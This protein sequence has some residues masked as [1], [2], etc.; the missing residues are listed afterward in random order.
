MNIILLWI[1]LVWLPL[2]LLIV[3][4]PHRFWVLA[5]LASCMLMMRMQ[6]QL[7]ES[8]GYEYGF[9]HLLTSHAADRAM[10][11]YNF[12]YAVYMLLAFYSP[13]T[14]GVVFMAASIGIFF[15]AFFSSSFVMLL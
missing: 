11:V 12:F 7:M 5:T 8:I 14:Q 4:K 6:V 3:H 9:L 10:V 1:D 2:A 13:N 15:M